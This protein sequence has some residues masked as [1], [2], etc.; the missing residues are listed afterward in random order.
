MNNNQIPHVITTLVEQFLLARKRHALRPSDCGAFTVNDAVPE[1]TN[2]RTG[3]YALYFRVKID[4]EN[5]GYEKDGNTFHKEWPRRSVQVVHVI[6]TRNHNVFVAIGGWAATRPGV[7]E[8]R[9]V[10]NHDSCWRD[11]IATEIRNVECEL[12]EECFS[13]VPDEHRPAPVMVPPF[14]HLESS[15]FNAFTV[16][17]VKGTYDNEDYRYTLD[18]IKHVNFALNIFDGEQP[19]NECA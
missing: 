7:E 8:F 13:H 19:K 17:K 11:A 5:F 4:Q 6:V 15:G 14:I 10:S 16:V 1:H 18:E 3:T 12:Y 2:V 9:N